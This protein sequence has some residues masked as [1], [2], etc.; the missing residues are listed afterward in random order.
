VLFAAAGGTSLDPIADILESY[1][2]HARTYDHID[3]A[4]YQEP[5]PYFTHRLLT[6]LV[7]LAY[8]AVSQLS[9][10]VDQKPK[11]VIEALLR[12]YFPDQDDEG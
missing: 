9:Q 4:G 6:E 8:A 10:E 5:S 12:K 1:D 11:V 3:D 7:R 2:E